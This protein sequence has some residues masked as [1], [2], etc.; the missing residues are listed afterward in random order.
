MDNIVIGSRFPLHIGDHNG[1]GYMFQLGLAMKGGCEM[2]MNI[3]IYL[4][5]V[6]VHVTGKSVYLELLYP[7]KL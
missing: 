1:R 4:C 6:W 3:E 7:T 2:E 5:Q